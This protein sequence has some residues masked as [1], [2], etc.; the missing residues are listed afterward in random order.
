MPLNPR[1]IDSD[2]EALILN[3]AG[4]NQRT[5]VLQSWVGKRRRQDL[6]FRTQVGILSEKFG[7]SQI[8]ANRESG[9]AMFN[10]TNHKLLPR[11]NVLILFEKGEQIK[12][13]VSC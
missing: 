12:L 10:I 11:L 2:E 1:L 5:I 8:I 4:A 13:P 6:Y 7:K 3:R 9:P